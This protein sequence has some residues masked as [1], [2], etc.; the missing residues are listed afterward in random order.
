MTL[1]QKYLL[2]HEIVHFVVTLPI[3][4]ICWKWFS[5]KAACTVILTT[6]LVDIDHLIFL[7][8]KGARLN[9]ISNKLINGNIFETGRPILIL[10]GFDLAL[11]SI[12]MGF[13]WKKYNWF[14]TSFGLALFY[15]LVVDMVSY[16]EKGVMPWEYLLLNNFL[17]LKSAL[18]G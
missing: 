7:L 9:S 1:Y 17:Q 3:C 8:Y 6:Y 12:F 18:S 13:Y 10:H 14:F 2:Y 5:K 4:Y 15:H 11:L 16:F